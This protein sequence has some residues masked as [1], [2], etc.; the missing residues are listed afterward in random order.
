MTAF[1]NALVLLPIR[2]RFGRYMWP[3][4]ELFGDKARPH[5]NEI[6]FWIKVSFDPGLRELGCGIN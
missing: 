2:S 5:R 3:V 6:D 4:A 1:E